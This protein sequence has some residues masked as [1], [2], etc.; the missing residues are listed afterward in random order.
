MFGIEEFVVYTVVQ[1]YCITDVFQFCS[2]SDIGRF[3]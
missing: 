1:L 3:D 2:F